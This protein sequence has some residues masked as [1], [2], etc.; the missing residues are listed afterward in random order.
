MRLLNKLVCASA[1]IL[2]SA[3]ASAADKGVYLGADYTYTM[4]DSDSNALPENF[5]GYAP[6]VGYQFNKNFAVELGYFGTIEETE[7]S[8]AAGGV[9]VTTDA[10]YHSIYGDFIGSYP[11][12]EQLSL[13]GAIGYERI[14]AEA[15]TTA[16]LGT[17]SQSASVEND[18]N[19]YR[20]GVG[21]KYYFTPEIAAR[22]MVRYVV[23]DFAGVENYIQGTV[24]LS[25]QF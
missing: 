21:A 3:S 1:L 9:S 10:K 23:T 5:S 4:F 25:Y 19:A 18:V 15:N 11:L 12:N 13:L 14:Y 20:L 16:T 2:A 24:G 8:T 7:N 22:T 6:Y 17:A